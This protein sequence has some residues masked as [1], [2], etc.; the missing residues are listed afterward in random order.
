MS[1]RWLALQSC[2]FRG[3]DESPS[4]SNRGNFLEMVDAFGKMNTKIGEVVLGNAP[5]NATYTSPN[6]QKEILSIMANRVRQR[7]RKEIGDAKCSI[8]VDEARDTPSQEQIAII[9]RFVNGNEILT[10]RFFAIKSVSDTT[11][12]NL[13]N[14]IFDVLV[15]FNIQ[16]QNMR[17]QGYDDANNMRGAWNGLQALFLRDCPYAYYVHC[18]AHRLQ[19]TLV[20]AAR[21]VTAINSLFSDLDNVINMIRSSRKRINELKS[22]LKKE[23]EHLLEIGEQET[24]SGANQIG[25]LQRAGGTR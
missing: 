14:Q 8:L 6:I 15:R 25:N 11:S 21:D 1:V 9:L 19:L 13:K 10:E 12:L 5:K 20:S 4:S 24:R 16:V 22:S 23:I 17:G 3:D 18:F 2:S 7:I